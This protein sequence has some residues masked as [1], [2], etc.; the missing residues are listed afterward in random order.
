MTSILRS[1]CASRA[2][3]AL[4]AAPAFAF[5]AEQ[6]AAGRAAYEQTCV[7]LPRREPAPA[8][9]RVAR[10]RRVPRPLGQP[11]DER[12][13]RASALDDAARQSRRPAGGNVRERRR[14]L[15]ASERRRAERERDRRQH[16]GARRPRP[17]GPS[18]RR[19]PQPRSAERAAG[20][21]GRHRRRHGAELHAGHRRDAAQSRRRRLAH[22]APRLQRDELQPARRRSRP[23]T[24]SSCSSRGS[25]RCATAARINPRRSSTTARCISRTRAA[26]CRRSTRARAI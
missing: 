17:H 10:R 5:T 4:S 24:R 21:D 16:D 11:R 14:V 8:A 26:S 25:G 1:S 12:S 6:A 20:A 22:A 9:E 3:L 13:H 2:S 19:R 23:T 7:D 18:R 15:A